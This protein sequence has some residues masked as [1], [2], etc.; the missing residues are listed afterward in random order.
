MARFTKYEIDDEGTPEFVLRMSETE[1]LAFLALL[2]PD[3]AFG[4]GTKEHEELKDMFSGAFYTEVRDTVGRPTP[5]QIEDEDG[6]NPT[7]YLGIM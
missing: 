2:Q 1:A 3:L 6:Y 7:L 4:P 5:Y